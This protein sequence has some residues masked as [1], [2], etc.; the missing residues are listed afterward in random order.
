MPRGDP[1]DYAGREQ[2]RVKHFLLENYLTGWGY[3]IGSAW[4]ALVYIDGF[5]GPWGSRDPEFADSSFGTAFR[6]LS[7]T[8]ERLRGKGKN[9]Q[10]LCV[11]V[12]K[13]HSAFGRLQSF[14][15]SISKPDCPA[16]ALE[17]RFIDHISGIDKRIASCGQ[18]PFKFV[19]LDQKGWAATPMEDLR[20]FLIGRSCEVLFTLMTSFLTRFLGNDDRAPSYH[21]L[22]GRPEVLDAIRTLPKGTGEREEA[23]VREYCKSLHEICG[24][25]YVSEAVILDPRKEKIKYYLIFATNHFKGVEVFK[26]AELKAAQLQDSVRHEVNIS[27]T[28]Q[29]LLGFADSPY[30][31]LKAYEL[32]KSYL[33]KAR[34]KALE[35]LRIS[36][37]EGVAYEELFCKTMS[38]PL[39]TPDDLVKWLHDLGP[40]VNLILEGSKRRKP[41]PGQNDRV[42]IVDKQGLK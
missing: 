9:V 7:Q 10:G 17:G 23:A 33:W 37:L 28:G 30:P 1:G 36:P 5:A 16:I 20:P 38:F 39:V 34:D 15:Q 14:A 19:F 6:T 41:S 22:F 11:F 21:G 27:E 35:M 13:K 32:R 25:R 29:E 8:V 42:L 2:E 26:Q 3:R 18:K 4:D 40:S 31:S 12:E 24:F